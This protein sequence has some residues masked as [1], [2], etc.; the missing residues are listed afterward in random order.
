MMNKLFLPLVILLSAVY[1]VFIHLFFQQPLATAVSVLFCLLFI[2][3]SNFYKRRNEK[4][5]SDITDEISENLEWLL[6]HDYQNVNALDLLDE[7]LISKINQKIVRIAEVLKTATEKSTAE[8]KVLE[9]FISDV[10]HQVKTPMTNLKMLHETIQDRDLPEQTRNEM[11]NLMGT[12]LEKL[13][14]LLSFMVKTSR[15]EA[16]LIQLKKQPGNLFDTL[17]EALSDITVPAEKKQI[18]IIVNCPEKY[19][20][21]HDLK[22]TAEA[23]FNVLENAVKYSPDNSSITVDVKR[24]E[25]YTR[26]NITD[27]GKGIPEVHYGKI[28]QRFYREEA[29]LEIEGIGIGLY[30]TR[31]IIQKQNGYIMV[32]SVVGDGSTFSVFLPNAF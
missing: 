8:K 24:G 16:G 9:G 32:R 15:L 25:M 3:G 17:A 30:L 12:Q 11:L 7:T 4:I 1:C 20:L 21:N 29:N 13:E 6:N 26:I 31:E 14:F 5:I 18:R 2:L 22:W 27:Q 10:S 19:I 28:F 23:L